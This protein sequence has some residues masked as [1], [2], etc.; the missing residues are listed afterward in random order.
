MKKKALFVINTLGGGGA[1]QALADLLGQLRSPDWDLYLYVMLGQGE[2]IRR[3]PPEVKLLNRHYDPSDVLSARGRRRMAGHLCLLLPRRLA[4]L[5]CLPS[6]LG[7]GAQMLRRG[8][9]RWDRLLWEVIA[10]AAWAPKE[11]FDLAVAYIEGAATDYVARRIRAGRKAAFLHLV[12]LAEEREP[13][14]AREREVYG[15]FR[16]IFSVSEEVRQFFQA[17]YPQYAPACRVLHNFVDRERIRL[18]AAEAGGF[19]D[20]Y[21]GL[22]I[23]TVARLNPQ[24]ALEVSVRAMALV[25]QAGLEARWY[26]LGEGPERPALEAQIRDAGLQEAFLLPGA[27]DNPYPYFR[28]A[29]LYVHCSR[30]E[31]RSI[32]VQE[33][34]ALG[35]PI[36]LSDCAGNREQLEDGREGL[37]VPLEPEAIAGAILRLA[38]DPELRRRLGENAARRGEDREDSRKLLAILEGAD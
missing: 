36:I 25:R 6:L 12:N 24:K 5:R 9:L 38:K 29:D 27:T 23:L 7:R 16:R 19:T 15:C 14:T 4:L 2:L 11:E 21:T 34:M 33:A 37:M 31:G 13:P 10:E 32:A 3:I 30:F 28:Q 1:E 26:V 18:R 17:R 22:R 8:R 20:G 35:C